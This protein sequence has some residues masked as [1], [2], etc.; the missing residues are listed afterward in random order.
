MNNPD[1]RR[2][3]QNLAPLWIREVREGRNAV[4]AGLL[5]RAM[6]E[7]CGDVRGLRIV[8]TGCGEGRFSRM[9][10]ARDAGYVLGLDL[11][12]PLVEA[13]R[14]LATGRDEYRV[15]DVQEM[16]GIADNQ[17]DLAVSYL[18]Q[19]DLP[20][21]DANNREVFRILKPG[22]RF[23]IANIH[24]MRSAFG[25]WLKADDGKKLHVILDRY[26]EE[27]ERTW[28]MMGVEFTN[29]HRSLMT[30]VT[31]FLAAGFVFEGLVE[32]TATPEDIARFPELGE[33]ARVPNFILYELAKPA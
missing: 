3:W 21:V 10:A 30:T 9:L 5:D 8:D 14:A 29:F 32:P 11:C 24:P 22:G 31:G 7:A 25:G 23:A 33:E 20:E 15:A 13:A 2:Q 18:S 16:P 4:R 28:T 27:N 19:C 6:I 12:E 17:F 1:L 26:F